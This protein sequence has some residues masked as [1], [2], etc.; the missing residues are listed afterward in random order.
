[1]VAAVR[2]LAS[3]GLGL[4]SLVLR[5]LGRQLIPRTIWRIQ[6]H[7]LGTADLAAI[8]QLV[9]P[10]VMRF[11][12]CGGRSSRLRQLLLLP[13]FIRAAIS[14]Y[15]NYHDCLVALTP[16]EINNLLPFSSDGTLADHGPPS[17]IRIFILQ[18]LHLPL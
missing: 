6:E 17:F 5:T 11:E 12:P 4:D 13:P 15:I 8:A 2:R 3:R 7:P 10:I 1:M 18:S 16:V 9:Q 14:H